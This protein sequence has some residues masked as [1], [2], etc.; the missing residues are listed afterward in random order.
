M[1]QAQY[2][3][4]ADEVDITINDVEDDEQPPKLASTAAHSRNLPIGEKPTHIEEEVEIE[5][6]IVLQERSAKPWRTLLTGLPSPTSALLSLLTLLINVGLVLAATDFLYRGKTFHPSDDVSFA[7]IGYVSDL[8]AKLLI[9]EP[10]QSKYPIF[11]YT[12]VH[13]PV[14]PHDLPGWQSMGGINFASNETDYTT[15]VTLP[16]RVGDPLRPWEQK[17]YEWVTR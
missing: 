4:L 6:T 1:T 7:R 15:V 11:V 9:R 2:D 3:I 16:L 13:N 10:D 12:K 17:Q 14:P 8:E 5:E